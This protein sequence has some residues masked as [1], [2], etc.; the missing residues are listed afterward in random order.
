[1]IG[2]NCSISEN[3]VV[4]VAGDEEG[5]VIIGDEVNIEAGAIVQAKSV[6]DGTMIE[7]GAKIGKGAVVGKVGPGQANTRKI[8]NLTTSAYMIEVL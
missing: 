1:M 4:G 7:V 3:A 5:D 2:K 8:R 6:G